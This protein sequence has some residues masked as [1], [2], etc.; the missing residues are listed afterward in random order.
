MIH[1]M[2]TYAALL[3]GIMPSNPNMSNEKLRGVF[4][5]LGFSNVQSVISSGNI[6]FE[7]RAK[8]IPTLEDRIEKELLKVLGI[9]SPAFIRSKEELEKMIKKNPFKNA[10][11]N[12]KTYLIVSFLKKKPGEI[13]NTVDLT[14]E[15]TP[16][17][18]KDIENKY[19]K[20]VTTRTWKTVERIVKKMNASSA[21]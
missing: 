9:K 16:D 8:N 5:D 20:A 15:K 18:M 10:S 11:H 2:T 4:K 17:F 1:P 13:F 12:P 19:S 3:R 21:S 14:K 7:A 6:I